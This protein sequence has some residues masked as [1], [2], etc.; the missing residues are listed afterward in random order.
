MDTQRVRGKRS[1]WTKPRHEGPNLNS[2]MSRSEVGKFKTWT[3]WAGRKLMWRLSSSST[4]SATL[5]VVDKISK[6]IDNIPID[7]TLSLSVSPSGF[8]ILIS[9]PSRLQSNYML[10]HPGNACVWY[11][12]YPMYTYHNLCHYNSDAD[13]VILTVGCARPEELYLPQQTANTDWLLLHSHSA[14]IISSRPP[15]E[16]S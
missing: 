3:C 4:S 5:P 11:F 8:D 14:N 10:C 6:Q 15:V 12:V 7:S 9:V 16:M 1:K 13:I 2:I